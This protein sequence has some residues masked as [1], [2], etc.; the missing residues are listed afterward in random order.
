MSRRPKKPEKFTST[1][2]RW[3]VL[4]PVDLSLDTEAPVRHAID[5]AIQLAAELTLLY[6]VDLHSWRSRKAWPPSARGNQVPGL[7]IHRLV[8]PGPV[9]ETIARYADFIDADLIVMNSR[10]H[11][12]W[13][14]FWRKPAA[15]Q[16]MQLSHRPIW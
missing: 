1:D 9:S 11:R 16:L 14:R 3:K 5:V 6:V 8:L 10:P 2:Q 7:D 15:S 4:A 12:R 13:N